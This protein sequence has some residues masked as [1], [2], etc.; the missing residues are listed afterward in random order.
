MKRKIYI[1]VLIG[2]ILFIS[3]LYVEN[4]SSNKVNFPK[5]R[6]RITQDGKSIEIPV[7]IADKDELWT[8]GLMYR[9]DIP[10]RYGMIFI[11]P[12][13]TQD[14]FWMKNTYIPL[15]IAFIDA[16]GKIFNIQRMVPCEGEECPIYTSPKP[17]RYALEVKAGFFEKFGF[18]EGAKISLIR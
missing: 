14:G 4:F 6:L 16:E 2:L 10:W 9:K 18:R 17:Y 12:E 1:S 7:E 11:F 5:G 15:D 13:D 3:V 8:L